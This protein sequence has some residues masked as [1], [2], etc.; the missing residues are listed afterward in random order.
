MWATNVRIAGTESNPFKC[1]LCH[2]YTRNRQLLKSECDCMPSNQILKLFTACSH[3]MQNC[4]DGLFAQCICTGLQQNRIIKEASIN[5]DLSRISGARL[6]L[7]ICLRP[8][9]V[10]SRYWS[11]DPSSTRPTATRF[12]STACRSPQIS[13]R[14]VCSGATVRSTSPV[15]LPYRWPVM[16]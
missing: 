4:F 15:S 1:N 16:G 11:P 9:Q 12:C 14:T 6:I 8:S 13:C 5:I 10:A 3:V 7:S 2:H